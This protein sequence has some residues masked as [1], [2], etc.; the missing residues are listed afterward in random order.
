MDLAKWK[1]AVVHLECA[2][3]GESWSTRKTRMLE[4]KGAREA[5]I[6]SEVEFSEI[7]LQANSTIRNVRHTGTAIFARH[8]GLHYLLTARH[9]LHDPRAADW[10]EDDARTS[11]GWSPAEARDYA[12]R[13]RENAIHNLI[14]RVPKLGETI[15]D[16]RQAPEHIMNIGAGGNY[17]HSF[18]TPDLDL[19]V[20]L[21]DARCQPF[22]LEL[23]R[24]GY[25]PITTADIAAGPSED[26]EEVF[27]VGFPGTSH[28]GWRTQSRALEIWSSSLVSAPI[29]S[30]GRVAALHE[31]LAYFW[32]D[33]SVYPGN[34]GGPVVAGDRLVGIVSAQAMEPVVDSVEDAATAKRQLLA[35]I[36]FANIIKGQHVLA[37]IETQETKWRHHPLNQSGLLRNTR[38]EGP[39]A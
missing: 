9:V 11:F 38:P 25:R 33:L 19:A 3:D 16:E 39:A 15:S 14:F 31:E 6:I 20:L 8:N 12:D 26:G 30:F 28:V 21:L 34:S 5:G 36:P 17:N 7:E 29:A 32:A 24:V 10:A 27:T 18:S 35:R 1:S 4:A 22:L 37:L 23:Y 13:L 2:A